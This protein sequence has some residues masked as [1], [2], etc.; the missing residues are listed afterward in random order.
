[1]ARDE[2]KNYVG[3]LLALS[4]AITPVLDT[5]VE[6]VDEERNNTHFGKASQEISKKGQRTTTCQLSQM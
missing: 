5:P 3:G 1:L 4:A 2:P 6:D